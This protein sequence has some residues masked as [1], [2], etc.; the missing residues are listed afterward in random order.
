VSNDG[1]YYWLLVTFG[2]CGYN[3]L[4]IESLYLHIVFSQVVVSSR[5]IKQIASNSSLSSER[6]WP[7]AQLSTNQHIQQIYDHSAPSLHFYLQ[8]TVEPLLSGQ[9][10]CLPHSTTRSTASYG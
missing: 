8:L 7:S 10:H 5:V 2:F 3:S 9:G 4:L 1:L 6:I